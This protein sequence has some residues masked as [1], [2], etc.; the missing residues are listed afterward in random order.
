M[1]IS[2]F[3][4]IAL[5]REKNFSARTDGLISVGDTTPDVSLYSLLYTDTAG[6]LTIAD[7]DNGQEGQLISLINLGAGAISFST[8]VKSSD[9][10]SLSTNDTVVFVR[11]NSSWYELSRSHNAASEQITLASSGD[12]SPSVKNARVL[13]LTTTAPLLIT[14]IDDG[15]E[16]QTVT[17]IKS[18]SS[19][20]SLS[21]GAAIFS[22]STSDNF[23][24]QPSGQ[25]VITRYNSQWFTTYA[26][27]GVA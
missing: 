8:N 12:S 11:H 24:L 2:R 19:Y 15:Y 21:A 6:A 25:I 1:G 20:N 10:S 16:G 17:I 26:P 22:A 27:Y 13:V 5:G 4:S 18:G 3:Y 14:G 23:V 7:F 9:S